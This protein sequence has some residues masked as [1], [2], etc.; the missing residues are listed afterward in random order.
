MM[1]RVTA[2]APPSHLRR[3]VL[4]ASLALIQEEG[5][6]A[7]SMREVARRAGVS[8]QAPYHHFSDRQA[9]LAAL[10]EEGFMELAAR[11]RAARAEPGTPTERLA[12]LGRA[13]VDF[14]LE[15]SAHFRVMFRPELVSLERFPD[16]KSRADEAYGELVGLIGDLN[17]DGIFRDEDAPA[18]VSLAWAIVH[19]LASLTLDGPF[20]MMVPDAQVRSALVHSVLAFAGHLVETTASARGAPTA[21]AKDAPPPRRPPKRQ[22]RE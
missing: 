11:M 13:Y 8:H 10:A 17:R 5:L 21:R 3:R 15:R 7:L 2:S 4:D 18:A 20:A 1:R 9:I 22:S 6:A 19:G 16:A 14:A 12:M